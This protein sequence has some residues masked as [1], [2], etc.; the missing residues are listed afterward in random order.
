MKLV[1][2]QQSDSH[3][4][5]IG[6]LSVLPVFFDIRSKKAVVAGASPAAAW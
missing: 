3:A 6:A 2:R 5:R 4:P 1:S